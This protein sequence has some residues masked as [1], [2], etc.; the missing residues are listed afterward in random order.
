M[1]LLR[2]VL[3]ELRGMFLADARLALSTL[4][5]VAGVGGLRAGRLPPLLAGGVL[6]FGCLAILAGAAF[7]HARGE[8]RR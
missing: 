6:L 3:D 8:V 4:L 5:L 1:T 2:A 7:R